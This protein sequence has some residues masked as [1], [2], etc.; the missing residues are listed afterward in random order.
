MKDAMKKHA[1]WQF[2]I[3]MVGGFMAFQVA[4][5]TIFSLAIDGTPKMI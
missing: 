1:P 4:L 3:G 2:A 5:V